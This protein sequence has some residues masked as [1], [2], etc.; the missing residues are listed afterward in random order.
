MNAD[1]GDKMSE[2]R[3]GYLQSL[4]EG[5]GHGDRELKDQAFMAIVEIESLQSQLAQLEKN[6]I[7]LIAASDGYNEK[8][9]AMEKER[10][11]EALMRCFE[12]EMKRKRQGVAEKLQSEL[13]DLKQKGLKQC[14]E[15]A[16]AQRECI[17]SKAR[18]KELE[19]LLDDSRKHNKS[20]KEN[21][22]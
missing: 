2:L 22:F 17:Q 13:T 1:K 4:A 14:G 12:R 7:D 5:L 11:K 21:P 10:D 18:I 6:H 8:L 3:L 9:A 16:K 19:F 20:D 15:L